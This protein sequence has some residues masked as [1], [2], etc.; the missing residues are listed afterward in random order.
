MEKESL[1][2]ALREGNTDIRWKETGEAIMSGYHIDDLSV[3]YWEIKKVL[4]DRITM[5]HSDVS[6]EDIKT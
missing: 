3:V 5:A 1:K 6:E 4:G 2:H